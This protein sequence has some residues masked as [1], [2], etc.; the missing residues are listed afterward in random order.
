[1]KETKIFSCPRFPFHDGT[2]LLP[3]NTNTRQQKKVLTNAV[4]HSYSG[5]SHVRDS[6]KLVSIIFGARSHNS[7]ASAAV[8]RNGSIEF[9][10]EQRQNRKNTKQ[11]VLHTK[12]I[13]LSA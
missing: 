10:R 8:D 12:N 4:Y 2:F 13:D 7:R 5:A 1:M 11:M 9:V 3:T 6:G